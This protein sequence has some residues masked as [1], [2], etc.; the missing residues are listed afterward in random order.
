[1][2]FVLVK[3]KEMLG[4]TVL[5]SVF[6]RLRQVILS[7]VRFA[8]KDFIVLDQIVFIKTENIVLE[9]VVD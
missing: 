8:I 2:K 3:Q 4:T 1:M 7:F 6:V 9:I 5:M